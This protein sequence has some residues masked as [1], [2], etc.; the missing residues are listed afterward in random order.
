[1]TVIPDKIFWKDFKLT[2]PA[3]LGLRAGARSNTYIG[4]PEAL[5]SLRTLDPRHKHSGM[6]DLKTSPNI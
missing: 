2:L 4:N 5:S 6:T 1:M 3:P